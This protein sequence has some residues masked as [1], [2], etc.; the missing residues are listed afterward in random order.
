MPELSLRAIREAFSGGL[1]VA[2][3]PASSNDPAAAARARAA[4]TL[5]QPPNS[6]TAD[7]QQL[8]VMELTSRLWQLSAMWKQH[9]IPPADVFGL[10]A[11]LVFP[12]SRPGEIVLY[13]QPKGLDLLTPRSI[14]GLLV[15]WA[16]R[17]DHGAEL[18]RQVAARQANAG[19]VT[20][21]H[22][23]L[24]ELSVT[25]R[26]PTSAGPHLDA[27]AA[28]LEKQKL[29]TLQQRVSQVT[30]AVPAQSAPNAPTQPKTPSAEKAAPKAAA[31]K[32]NPPPSGQ[33][34]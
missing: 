13:D 25:E 10:F 6:R 16:S 3:P 19:D 34:K 21:G 4:A 2:D 32:P 11:S 22:L 28:Q 9:N 23:L 31:E 29:A 17:Y 24:V 18:K 7:P 1:P 26:D 30:P 14:G 33:N 8:A 15:E 27:L 12:A 20:R 5:V